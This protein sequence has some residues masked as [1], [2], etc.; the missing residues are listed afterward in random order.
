MATVLIRFNGGN[1]PIVTGDIPPND[2]TPI[3]EPTPT[4]FVTNQAFIVVGGDYCFG[5]DTDATYE[6]LWVLV[7]AIEGRQTEVTF[8]RRLP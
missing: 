3:S 5:L 4:G 6:P 1:V 2:H 7:Q 8:R